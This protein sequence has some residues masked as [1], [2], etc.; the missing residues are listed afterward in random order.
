MKPATWTGWQPRQLLLKRETDTLTR[1]AIFWHY[2]HYGNQGGT[3]GA[4]VRQG[5]YKLIEFFGDRPSELY[6]LREDLSEKKNLYEHMPEK[7]A[8]LESLLHGWQESTGAR[9]PA[10]NP[11]FDPDAPV[12]H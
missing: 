11:G 4:A 2:P 6:N 1:E 10:E 5:A 8:A 7:A 12:Y 9:F 3:P